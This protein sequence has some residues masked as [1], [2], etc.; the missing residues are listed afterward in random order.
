MNLIQNIYMYYLMW[1]FKNELI[2]ATRIGVRKLESSYEF[3]FGFP[4]EGDSDGELMKR[5][6]ID[7]FSDNEIKYTKVSKWGAD[8]T[9]GGISW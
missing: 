6:L 7:W 9:V 4:F 3:S 5:Y 1:K 8:I 2:K